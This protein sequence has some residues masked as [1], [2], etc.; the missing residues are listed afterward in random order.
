MYACLDTLIHEM[1]HAVAWKHQSVEKY[2]ATHSDEWGIAYAKI[3]RKY[4]EEDGKTESYE[5]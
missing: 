4:F 1:A 5:Y 3:Y 2:Y